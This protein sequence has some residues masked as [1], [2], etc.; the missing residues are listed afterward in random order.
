MSMEKE[1][2]ERSPAQQ[3]AFKKA[4]EARLANMKAKKEDKEDPEVEEV[5]VKT[6]KDP[7]KVKPKI[8]KVKFEPE[9]DV[10]HEDFS[11]E[12]EDEPQP[13][14]PTPPKKEN[15]APPEPPK[16]KNYYDDYIIYT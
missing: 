5:V 4:R 6:R 1:K 8:T 13:R 11:S 3:E 10:K 12:E 16:P 15:K 7:Q 14:P 2:R 9:D